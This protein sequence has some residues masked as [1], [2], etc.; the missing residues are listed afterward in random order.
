M[1]LHQ[2]SDQPLTR[3]LSSKRFSP[4]ACWTKGSS[5]SG[6]F[7]QVWITNTTG[8]LASLAQQGGLGL[9]LARDSGLHCKELLYQDCVEPQWHRWDENTLTS[10]EYITRRKYHHT[11]NVQLCVLLR[12]MPVGGIC[13]AAICAATFHTLSTFHKVNISFH[14]EL[15]A[16]I[17]S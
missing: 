6:S 5:K 2:G 8:R 17:I 15:T 14:S 1:C 11:R 13:T 12:E 10:W 3:I 9:C 16:A 7:A 4:C